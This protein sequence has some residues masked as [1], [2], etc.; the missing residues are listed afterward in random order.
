M[1]QLNSHRDQNDVHESLWTNA[2]R[3]FTIDNTNRVQ[4]SDKHIIHVIILNALALLSL[5]RIL[6]AMTSCQ[7]VIKPQETTIP[8]QAQG[9]CND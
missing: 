5:T 9:N 2:T 8:L 6:V 3:L 4:E 1:S 7:Q